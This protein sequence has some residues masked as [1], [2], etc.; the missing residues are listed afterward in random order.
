[1]IDGKLCLYHGASDKYLT[2]AFVNL[3]EL[4]GDLLKHIE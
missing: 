3:D 4:V 1:V 2:V